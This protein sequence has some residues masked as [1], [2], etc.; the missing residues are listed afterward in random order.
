MSAV[1]SPVGSIVLGGSLTAN[2]CEF[3]NSSGGLLTYTVKPVDGS[4]TI[5]GDDF[6]AANR[7]SNSSSASSGWE[8]GYWV[9]IGAD[10]TSAPSYQVGFGG[11]SPLSS[12]GAPPGT[13]VPVPGAAYQAS[14]G[15]AFSLAA[16]V[17]GVASHSFNLAPGQTGRLFWLDD[18]WS[19]NNGGISVNVTVV[20]EPEAYGLALAGMGVVAVAMRRRRDDGKDACRNAA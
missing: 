4:A 13:G 16:G 9:Q 18:Q 17:A 10:A 6:V 19:D 2:G 1:G 11:G 5:A 3:T 7:F 15:S 8:W 12:N 14:A 20:P